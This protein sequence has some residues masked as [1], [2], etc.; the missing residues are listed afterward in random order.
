MSLERGRALMQGTMLLVF[1]AIALWV[2]RPVGLSLVALMALLKLQEART[3]W[4]PSDLI[5]KPLGLKRRA[6]VSR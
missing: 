5:L 6:A 3:D 4:C 2:S 1:A